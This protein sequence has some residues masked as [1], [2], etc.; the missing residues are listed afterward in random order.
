MFVFPLLVDV[1]S[2]NEIEG[3]IFEI[4]RDIDCCVDEE[5]CSTM[6]KVRK[7]I[8]RF[9]WIFSTEGKEIVLGLLLPTFSYHEGIVV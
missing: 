2:G 4:V 8:A 7:Y 5:Y 1:P 9:T 6:A 3:K